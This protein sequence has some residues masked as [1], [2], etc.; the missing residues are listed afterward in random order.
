MTYISNTNIN[1]LGGGE[2]D[3]KS[4][5]IRGDVVLCS[6][7]IGSKIVLHFFKP[8]GQAL[9]YF[10]FL[11][12]SAKTIK[13][14][15]TLLISLFSSLSCNLTAIC[16]VSNHITSAFHKIKPYTRLNAIMSCGRQKNEATRIRRHSF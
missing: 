13:F 11:T 5:K 14:P 7:K 8:N 9:H 4:W 3:L 1:Y 2:C 16:S 10:W 15:H 12:T 6:V